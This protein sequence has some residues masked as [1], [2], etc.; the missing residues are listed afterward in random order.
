M[1]ILVDTAEETTVSLDDGVLSDK[2]PQAEEQTLAEQAKAETPAVDQ[3]PD[4]FQMPEKFKDKSPE[5]IA[6]SYVELESFHGRQVNDL[7]NEVSHYRNLTDRFLSIEEKRQNDL[8]SAGPQTQEIEIDPAE[9]LQNPRRVMDEYYESRKAQDTEYKVLENR[10]NQIEGQLGQASMHQAHPDAQQ[11]FASPEFAQWLQSNPQRAMLAQSAVQSGNTDL[12]TYL[13]S[14]YKERQS[15]SQPS[16]VVTQDPLA[17]QQQNEIQA[18][19]EVSTETSS[20]G[21]TAGE[22]K[23]RFSRAKLVNLKINNPDEYERM[24]DQIVLA[25]HEGRV[26]P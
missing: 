1:S 12:A 15:L 18:A 6:K 13:L 16:Q 8:Q 3:A 20:T 19:Q 17:A 24:N 2:Q 14:E 23:P 5:E 25:Y 10:L 4:G 7:S 9:F 11:V 21:N 26:D 22:S